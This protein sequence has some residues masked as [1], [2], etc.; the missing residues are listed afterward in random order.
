[1]AQDGP[2]DG[3]DAL[4][5][6]QNIAK[7]ASA[8]QMTAGKVAPLKGGTGQTVA[9]GP[10]FSEF[11]VTATMADPLAMAT[12]KIKNKPT[13]VKRSRSRNPGAGPSRPLEPGQPDR[14][15]DSTCWRGL[16][17]S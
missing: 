1:L 12:R 16:P 15:E 13:G 3:S 10:G 14:N 7:A 6:P 17:G 9:D 4:I 11:P 2:E 5:R 8:E